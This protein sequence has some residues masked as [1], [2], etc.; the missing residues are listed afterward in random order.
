MYMAIGSHKSGAFE[1]ELIII[2][3]A[4][5]RKTIGSTFI[6]FHHSTIYLASKTKH[7]T[8]ELVK[9]EHEYFLELPS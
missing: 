6:P 2:N 1:M 9:K 5:P 4:P 3:Q 7:G 8:A